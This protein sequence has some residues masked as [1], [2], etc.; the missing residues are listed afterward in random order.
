MKSVSLFLDRM[1]PAT[2]IVL[3]VALVGIFSRTAFG[4]GVLPPENIDQALKLLPMLLEMVQMKNWGMVAALAIMLV[5]YL[6]RM[7]ILPKLA[8][9]DRALPLVSGGMGVL[10]AVA[11]SLAAGQPW[12][13]AIASGV[14]IGAAASG[15]WS[16]VFKY[17][18]P[19]AK[20]KP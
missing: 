3:L 8:I 18:L 7:Y 20:P 16:A 14:F 13:A 11:V 4:D 19:V 6:F 17:V 1:F 10:L 12:G 2:V 15:F 5:T 9:N